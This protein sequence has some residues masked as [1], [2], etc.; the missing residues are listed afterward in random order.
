MKSS[1]LDSGKENVANLGSV[2]KSDFDSQE[3]QACFSKL[4]ELV[5]AVKSREGQM[6]KT[7][8]LQYVIDYIHE[9]EDSLGFPT[10]LCGVFKPSLS[11]H[12]SGGPAMT[13]EQFLTLSTSGLTRLKGLDLVSGPPS[14]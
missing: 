2:A 11:T 7:E 9:L 13:T 3:M 4:M 14:Q 12:Q 8:L 1:H 10:G 6:D 5:P